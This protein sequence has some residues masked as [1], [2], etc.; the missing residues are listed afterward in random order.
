MS[1]LFKEVLKDSQTIVS[2]PFYQNTKTP[3]QLSMSD[4]EPNLQVTKDITDLI[5]YVEMLVGG[6]GASLTDSNLGNDS[7]LKTD[8]TDNSNTSNLLDTI[9]DFLLGLTPNC[10]PLTIQTVSNNA[11]TSESHYMT[12]LDVKDI[13]QLDFSDGNNSMSKTYRKQSFQNMNEQLEVLMPDDPLA[14]L[15][16]AS[17]GV[18]GLIIL[19]RLMEKSR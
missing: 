11:K 7:F 5:K 12:L 3:T 18:L 13:G 6:K 15:Y 14:L 4:K 2:Y 17:L 1:N 8:F 19:Y 16:F 10:Q 9:N